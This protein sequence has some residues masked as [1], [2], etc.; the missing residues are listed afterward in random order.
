MTFTDADLSIILKAVKFAAHKHKR[1]RRKGRDALPYINHPID[2]AELLWRVG[3]VRDVNTLVA[4]LLHD[5]IEDTNTTAANIEAEFGREVAGLVLEVSDDKTLPS[6]RR[7]QLQIEHAPHLSNGAKQIKLA[8]KINNVCDIS[9]APPAGWSLQ[10]RIEYL[11]WAERVV[12]GLRGA[13]R[14]LEDCFDE[15][16][17][18]ARAQ[19]DEEQTD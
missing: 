10:R 6:S 3:Q 8:D 2:V 15:A 9:Y 12:A 14:Q 1:Q 18:K 4:A 11:N 16:M 19:M 7:K 17:S 13:N 5:T